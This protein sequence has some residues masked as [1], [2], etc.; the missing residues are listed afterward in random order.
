MGRLDESVDVGLRAVACSPQD[1]RAAGSLALSYERLGQ[2]HHAHNY[3]LRAAELAPDDLK[4]QFA[5]GVSYLSVGDKPAAQERF[6]FVLGK[7]PDHA[8]AH[9]MLSRL[10]RYSEADTETF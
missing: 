8:Q 2:H 10:K 5:C 9:W 3:Y 6:E 4:L 1:P 7:Q